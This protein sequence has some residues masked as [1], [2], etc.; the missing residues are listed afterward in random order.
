MELPESHRYYNQK[1]FR[2]VLTRK[3]DSIALVSGGIDSVV[4]LYH[5]IYNMGFTPLVLTFNYGQESSKEIACARYHADACSVIH[6]S[7]GIYIPRPVYEE[8]HKAATYYPARNLVFIAMAASIAEEQDA[9]TLFVGF[10]P[11]PKDEYFWDS[12]I[13]FTDRLNEVLVLSPKPA[14]LIAPFADIDRTRLM[15]I[16]VNLGVD[17]T[18]TWSCT[19]N[20]EKACGKCVYCV[21]RLASFKTAGL[22]DPLDYENG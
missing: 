1:G 20:R 22:T 11:N 14:Q 15:H 5:V 18:K 12:T 2:P 21:N 3:I 4:M 8:K 6:L 13:K 17:Y 10:R 9:G 16:G 19:A 7:M